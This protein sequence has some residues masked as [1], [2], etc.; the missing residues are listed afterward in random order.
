MLRILSKF[1][2][3][4]LR[5][6]HVTLLIAS[7]TQITKVSNYMLN[8]LYAIPVNITI[9][10]GTVYKWKYVCCIF[11][12]TGNIFLGDIFV[13]IFL[14]S[15][16][17]VQWLQTV[18]LSTRQIFIWKTNSRKWTNYKVLLFCKQCVLLKLLYPMEK[19][20]KL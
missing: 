1:A 10:Y 14:C 6:I 18:F 17:M 15:Y 13:D 20:F 5:I 11:L 12:S 3:L 7:C 16:D 19:Y 8:F 9:P 4:P 2:L